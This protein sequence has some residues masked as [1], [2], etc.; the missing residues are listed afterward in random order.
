MRIIGFKR[1]QMLVSFLLESLGI[2]LLGGIAGLLLGSL[3]HGWSA[4]SSISSG[5]GG[6]KTVILKLVV[7][8][9]VIM[10]GLVFIFVMGRLGGLIPAVNAMR[11][12]L[13]ES[14]R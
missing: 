10:A 2:A 8:G 9:Q 11:L 13:L 1:W 3:T 5:Q 7:D 4:T 14:L 6:G 12:K